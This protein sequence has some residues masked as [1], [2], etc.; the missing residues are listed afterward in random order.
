[1][2]IVGIL[3]TTSVFTPYYRQSG[4]TK[5][6]VMLLSTFKNLFT[7]ISA[8][9]I[10]INILPK[11]KVNKIL[12]S[13]G[14]ILSLGFLLNGVFI[15]SNYLLTLLFHSIIGIGAGVLWV[16]PFS[17]SYKWYPNKIGLITGLLV[18]SQG[19]GSLFWFKIQQILYNNSKDISI[20]VITVSIIIFILSLILSLTQKENS[21]YKET[22]SI[23]STNEIL[24]N[25]DFYLILILFVLMSGAGLLSTSVLKFHFMSSLQTHMKSPS[26]AAVI[27][28]TAY[29]VFLAISIG[30]GKLSWGIIID[31]ISIKKSIFSFCIIQ[32]LVII[33]LF[34]FSHN[35]IFLYILATLYGLNIGG[36]YSII[37]KLLSNSFSLINISRNIVIMFF[38]YQIIMVTFGSFSSILIDAGKM[39]IIFILATLSCIIAIPLIMKL[40]KSTV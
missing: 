35:E 39:N 22:K 25:F 3:Y 13:G 1:M 11:V 40:N 30:I 9:Y 26:Q 38:L 32:S 36:I 4:F 21:D 29:G 27:A 18:L 5:S 2:M 10:S 19:F 8:I 7:F 23:L 28:G 31:K 6:N 24:K 37:V 20:T 16:L 17:I 34:L 15:T 12:I 33:F 14:F